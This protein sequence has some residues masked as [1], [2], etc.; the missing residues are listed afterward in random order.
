MSELQ[1]FE[2]NRVV[3]WD[4]R[5]SAHVES[6][7]YDLDGFLAGKTS[8]REIELAELTNVD[9]KR[10]LHLQ[11]HFGLDHVPENVRRFAILTPT[12]LGDTASNV[13]PPQS[14]SQASNR[15]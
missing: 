10:L 3:G 9:G 11:F 8:L 15:L 14:P 5:A 6:K 7:F 1:Y 2:V 13:V 4:H 12:C